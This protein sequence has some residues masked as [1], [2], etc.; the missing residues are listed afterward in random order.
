MIAFLVFSSPLIIGIK[1]LELYKVLAPPVV[2]FI[3]KCAGCQRVRIRE[4]DH[5]AHSEY[6][7]A[8]SLPT[9]GPGLRILLHRTLIAGRRTISIC[10]GSRRARDI[11]V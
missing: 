2:F 10:K 3:T 1:N 9:F 6:F 4:E 11:G 8:V 7:A 5:R